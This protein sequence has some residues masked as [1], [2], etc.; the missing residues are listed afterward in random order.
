[1]LLVYCTPLF[2]FVC[3]QHFNRLLHSVFGI[4]G[5]LTS[6][7]CW[8]LKFIERNERV[9]CHCYNDN[10]ISRMKKK[11]RWVDSKYW[12]MKTISNSHEWIAKIYEK[13]RSSFKLLCVRLSLKIGAI[14]YII[15]KHV[16]FHMNAAI[17][18]LNGNRMKTKRKKERKNKKHPAVVRMWFVWLYISTT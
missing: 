14:T 17:L 9:Q 8:M 4:S 13:N 16:A 11:N 6:C 7:W 12:K 10:K 15:I 5:K 1:M 2:A 3:V 18:I